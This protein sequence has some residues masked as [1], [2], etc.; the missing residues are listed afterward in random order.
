MEKQLSSLSL[1]YCPQSIVS[2]KD[3]EYS[4][5]QTQASSQLA[6]FG[7]PRPAE[8]LISDDGS[9]ETTIL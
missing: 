4:M 9:N 8:I 5:A 2:T 1:D 3:V 7:Y 6:A